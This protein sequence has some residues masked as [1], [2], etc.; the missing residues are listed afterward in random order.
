LSFEL[1]PLSNEK[2]IEVGISYAFKHDYSEAVAYFEAA[3]TLAA[4]QFRSYA[5]LAEVLI[6]RDGSL[7]GAL[8]ALRKGGDVVGRNDFIRRMLSPQPPWVAQMLMLSAFP[9]EFKDLE[10]ESLTRV[11]AIYYLVLSAEQHRRDRRTDSE[12]ATAETLLR[13]VGDKPDRFGKFVGLAYAHLDRR[14]EAA[15]LLTVSP[16]SI[17]S[18]ARSYQED[19]MIEAYGQFLLGNHDAAIARL[20]HALSMPGASSVAVIL[21]SPLWDDLRY[22]AGFQSL[23]GK[24]EY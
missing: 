15:R 23:L 16:E 8:Q 11:Q 1:D 3:I 12:R 18:N 22:H 5:H 14:E 17:N 7:N 6:G 21:V 19:V 9:E 2:A 20:D 10:L 13:L 24:Y 4:D